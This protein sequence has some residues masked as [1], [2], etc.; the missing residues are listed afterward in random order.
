MKR[1]P[2]LAAMASLSLVLLLPS[3]R[4]YCDEPTASPSNA[5]LSSESF[6]Q[7]CIA[8][9][10]RVDFIFGDN[11]PFESCHASTIVQTPNGDL[12]CAWFGGKHEKADNVSIW[13]SR[14]TKDAWVAPWKVAKV[15]EVPHWNPVLFRDANEIYLFFKVGKDET[16]WQTYW[17]K[18]KDSGKT[19]S[20]PVELVPGD[21]G[22]RGPVKDKPIVLSNGVWLAPA[23]V[24]KPH[25]WTPFADRSADHGKTW[26]RSKDWVI[27]KP[28]LRGI[29]AIQPTFW[30]NPPGHV[31]AL[32]RSASGHIWRADSKDFGRTWTPVYATALPNNNS[33][34]DLLRLKDG[35][36]LLVYN[37]VGKNWGPRTPLDLAVSTD[38]GQTWTDIAHLEDDPNKD[39]EYSY[40]A[41]V[42]TKGGIAISYTWRRER[43][44]CWQIPLEAL[45]P[46][47]QAK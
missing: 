31:H 43:I 22:G 40:P 4:A 29:G 39:A 44:R 16:V 15:R 42:Q 17:E 6:Q 33:G 27:K 45:T 5:P 26:E 35:R 11:R 8:A 47:T 34:I 19:W 7:R 28:K 3:S 14:F 2:R 10:G 18:S 21:V 38:D 37:P 23:S 46:D 32:T 9:G 12:L 25:K 41:I 20:K 36:I 30:E 13:M 1:L 24:E